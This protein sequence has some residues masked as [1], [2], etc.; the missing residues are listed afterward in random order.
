MK[1]RKKVIE[2]HMR[3]TKEASKRAK[4]TIVFIRNPCTK[5]KVIASLLKKI[6]HR[7]VVL[8]NGN[9]YLSGSLIPVGLL[10][11][12][13]PVQLITEEGDTTYGENGVK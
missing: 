9:H 7:P 3:S 4:N 11:T 10:C 5:Q 2:A 6:P 12:D 13:Y 8:D 1:E